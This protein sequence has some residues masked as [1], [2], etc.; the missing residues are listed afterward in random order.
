MLLK[1]FQLTLP[2][3]LGKVLQTMPFVRGITA[4]SDGQFE[5]FY[6]ALILYEVFMI[7]ALHSCAWRSTEKWYGEY[8]DHNIEPPETLPS[9]G[10]FSPAPRAGQAS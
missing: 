6:A 9:Y 3:V 4:L 8:G 5:A 10:I 1:A 7:A 2:S